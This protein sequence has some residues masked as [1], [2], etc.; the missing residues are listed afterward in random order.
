MITAPQLAVVDRPLRL[1]SGRTLPRYALG[2]ETYGTLNPQ[3]DNAILV[4]HTLTTTSRAAGFT[5]GSPKPGWWDAAIGPGKLLDT[6]RYFVICTDTLAAGRSTG[7]ASTDPATGRPYGLSFPVVEVADMVA[8][9]AQLLDRLEIERLHMAIGGCF[10]G[11]QV[12]VW[13]I[14]HPDR[15]RNAVVITATPD[16]S[17]HTIAIFAVMRRLIR[18]DQ[19]WNGGD[20]YGGPFPAVGLGNA[21][22]AGVPLWMSR[23]A[24]GARFGRR[25]E[26]GGPLGH[27]LETEF[28]VEAFLDRLAGNAPQVVDPNGLM[29]LTRAVEYFD[30]VRAYGSLASAF[31]RTTAR[32]LFV[33]YSNDWRYPAA[34]TALMHEA[35]RDLGG[36]SV[37]EV[38]DSPLGH[39]GFLLDVDGLRATVGRFM[40]DEPAMR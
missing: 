36:S 17:A 16:S 2:Y 4:C 33:S 40:A 26:R 6:D 19:N 34:E 12:L 21:I 37:H 5:S 13:A 15:V 20:Y 38:L 32:F 11:Q 18:S 27:T 35:I 8:A 25:T 28:A 30:L 31:A 39:G 10:G 22:A 23:E 9:Q 3:R 14:E 1:R 24:M 29:Y 7:P